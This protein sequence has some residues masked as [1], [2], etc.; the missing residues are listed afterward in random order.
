MRRR[1]VGVGRVQ[2][3]QRQQQ[4]FKQLGAD[5]Q[6]DQLRHAEDVLGQFR[7]HLEEFATKHK[8]AIKSD[9][10]FRKDF[11]VMCTQIGVDPLASTK[12]FWAEILGV[13]DFYYELGIQ[14][15]EICIQTRAEN[16]GLIGMPELLGRLR[17]KQSRSRQEASVDDVRRAVSKLKVLGGGFKLLEVGCST[18]VVSVPVELNQD[19]SQVLA[20]AQAHG[21]AV[22]IP[23]LLGTLLWDQDRAV[24]AV[25]RL[26]AEGMAWVDDQAGAQRTFWFM[27]V[28]LESRMPSASQAN[29]TGSG[30]ATT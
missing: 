12:G 9:P 24:R 26:V 29:A 11:Q 13:G 16:G 3:K 1:G 23:L 27:S 6:T 22:T 19:H 4:K 30:A 18:M 15:I 20:V 7:S 10:V 21:G 2:N 14:I 8:T 28:W 17:Q 5:L 25:D